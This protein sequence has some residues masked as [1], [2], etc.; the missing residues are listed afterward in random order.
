MEPTPPRPN[1]LRARLAKWAA[2]PYRFGRVTGRARKTPLWYVRE[3]D[4]I[5]CMSGWG[6]SSDWWKNLESCPRVVVRVG[7]R[8]WE[9]CGKILREPAEVERVLSLFQKKYRRRTVATFYHMDWLS[10]AAFRLSP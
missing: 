9:T 8:R 10:L 3:G 7:G 1:P 5:F 2:L 4:T 6:P